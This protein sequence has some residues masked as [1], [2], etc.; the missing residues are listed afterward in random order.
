ML[1]TPLWAA[2][3]EAMQRGEYKWIKKTT[4]KMSLTA[5]VLAIVASVALFI[6]IKPALHILSDDMIAPDYHLLLAMCLM[7]IITAFTSPY[8]MVLN[9][10]GI[11]KYQIV[12]Y[13]V[14]ALISL[15]LKYILGARFG[16]LAITWTGT[17]TY[18]FLL[19]VPTVFKAMRFVRSKLDE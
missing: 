2:N 1:S 17:V 8:F 7:Q 11:V 14:Y 13:A 3:G 16:M 19:T 9:A 5:A 12:I 10:A 18:L 6:L 15:S 4:R